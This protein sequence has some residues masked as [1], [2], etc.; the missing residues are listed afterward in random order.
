MPPSSSGPGH[1]VFSQVIAGSTPAG[2]TLDCRN[3]LILICNN[4]LNLKVSA[5]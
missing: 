1:P 2:G 5:I 3:N 4:Y